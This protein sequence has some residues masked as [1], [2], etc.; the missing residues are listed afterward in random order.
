MINLYFK[1]SDN[2]DKKVY[3]RTMKYMTTLDENGNEH[4]EIYQPEKF[5]STDDYFK[6]AKLIARQAHD[7]VGNVYNLVYGLNNLYI[8]YSVTDNTFELVNGEN[9][10]MAISASKILDNIET[11]PVLIV[12]N[13]LNNQLTF[14]SENNTT[15]KYLSKKLN[16]LEK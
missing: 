3:M 2:S 5:I 11:T 14:G 8:N 15:T 1:L 16:V 12:K 13:M 9:K 6:K 10:D 4:V 7:K